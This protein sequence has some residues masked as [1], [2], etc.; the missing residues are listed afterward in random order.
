MR[1]CPRPSCCHVFQRWKTVGPWT[2]LTNVSLLLL[3]CFM[4]SLSTYAIFPGPLQDYASN[5]NDPFHRGQTSCTNLI[6]GATTTS[7]IFRAHTPLI[8]PFGHLNVSLL[9]DSRVPFSGSSSPT[10]S[11]SVRA[12]RAL[13]H[14]MFSRFLLSRALIRI[15]GQ[16]KTGYSFSNI[17]KCMRLLDS[18]RT[19]MIQ[20]LSKSNNNYGKLSDVFQRWKT[21]YSR[22]LLRG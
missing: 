8:L 11:L 15:A 6:H 3:S 16:C 22:R 10:F 7:L 2:T 5:L 19:V 1:P 20:V 4:R 14:T 12:I 18:H 13:S 9:P 17:G 21:C